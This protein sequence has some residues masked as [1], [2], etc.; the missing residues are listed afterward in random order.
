M[1]SLVTAPERSLIGKITRSGL[2]TRKSRPPASTI[3]ASDAAMPGVLLQKRPAH[4]RGGTEPLLPR[5]ALAHLAVS[6]EDVDL[7]GAP[8]RLPAAR[9]GGAVEARPVVER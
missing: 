6:D 5:T 8:A 2:D 3:V 9:M 7:A 4:T 1:S